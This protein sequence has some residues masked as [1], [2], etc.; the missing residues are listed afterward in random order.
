MKFLR[1]GRNK[2]NLNSLL[3][4]LKGLLELKI[5]LLIWRRKQ[6]R[7]DMNKDKVSD[8]N[9]YNVYVTFIEYLCTVPSILY[10]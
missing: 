4:I 10:T 8:L 9:M 7:M 2:K 3:S 6:A 5:K 1:L